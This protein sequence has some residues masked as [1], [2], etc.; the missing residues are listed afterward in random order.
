[1][2][3]KSEIYSTFKSTW[4]KA[5]KDMNYKEL[6]SGLKEIMTQYMDPLKA[7]KL[8]AIKYE[9]EETKQILYKN[10]DDLLAANERLEDL[11]Q[12]SEDL[13]ALSKGMARKAKDLNRCCI[14]L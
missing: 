5:D 4:A 13:A 10:I 8:L 7:D 1:L 2:V 12:K 11:V 9:L 6:E 3:R 14:I